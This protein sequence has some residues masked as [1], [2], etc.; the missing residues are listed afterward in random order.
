MLRI[1]TRSRWFPNHL[2]RNHVRLKS[3]LIYV[4]EVLR[5]SLFLALL[6]TTCR[7]NVE[8]VALQTILGL[9]RVM[10]EFHLD[11]AYQYLHESPPLKTSL[12]LAD[13]K[14]AVCGLPPQPHDPDMY[15]EHPILYSLE[16]HPFML[17]APNSAFPRSLS[18]VQP[19]LLPPPPYSLPDITVRPFTNND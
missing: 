8:Q 13:L 2:P 14:R 15:L 7:G 11:L 10:K 16:L 3:S 18:H 4:L 6:P 5:Q 17:E 19:R 12:R 9:R 1:F